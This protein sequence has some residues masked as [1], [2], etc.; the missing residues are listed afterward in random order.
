[1]A[2][3]T[4]VTAGCSG[5]TAGGFSVAACAS[6]AIACWEASNSE[7]AVAKLPADFGMFIKFSNLLAS[8]ISRILSLVKAPRSTFLTTGLEIC[9]AIAMARYVAFLR[10]INVGG[11]VLIKMDV[12]RKQ[13]EKLGFENV[14]TVLATGNVIFD[15]ADGARGHEEAAKKIEIALQKMMKRDVKVML[16]SIDE[17]QKLVDS[18]PFK[19]VKVTKET[20]LYVTFLGD[21]P[22]SKLKIPYATPEK[23]FQILRVTAGEVCS[24]LVISLEKKS[25]DL[26]KIIEKEFGKN[27]TTRNWNTV[28]KLLK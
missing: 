15:L 6:S 7:A 3:L 1:M 24:F 21:K 9:Y 27:V 17:I 8:L 5:S 19:K 13:F 25:V 28:L 18:E 22:T 23:D 11:N 12:L 14:K 4:F 26:M 2:L 16:R 10:G 20:R